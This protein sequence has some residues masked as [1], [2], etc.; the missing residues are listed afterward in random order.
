MHA[1]RGGQKDRPVMTK[2][3]G[4][5]FSYMVTRSNLIVYMTSSVPNSSLVH[6]LP[7]TSNLKRTEKIKRLGKHLDWSLEI[8][9]TCDTTRL[10]AAV[11]F[12][13]QQ[14]RTASTVTGASVAQS[15]ELF[16]CPLLTEWP[17]ENN[18]WMAGHSII[19]EMAHR[20]R[21]IKR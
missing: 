14:S 21:K 15:C 12:L 10:M 6:A 16:V 20:R 18:K 5:T 19:T 13:M 3:R 4:H 2:A 7:F 8:L 9:P 17:Q 1:F 11:F